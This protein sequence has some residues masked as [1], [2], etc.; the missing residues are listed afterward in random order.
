MVS[1]L[2][3]DEDKRGMK[4]GNGREGKGAETMVDGIEVGSQEKLLQYGETS[5]AESTPLLRK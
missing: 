2:D 1:D 4:S 3:N 5:L